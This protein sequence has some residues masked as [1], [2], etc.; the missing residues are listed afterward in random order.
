M[1]GRQQIASLPTAISEL[2]KNAHDA[3]ARQVVVDFYRHDHLFVLRDD[4][5]GMTPEEFLDRWLTLGTESKLVENNAVVPPPVDPDQKP[6]PVL[7]EK[8][9]GRL[10]VAMLG[11]HL[12]VL[13]RAKSVSGKNRSRKLSAAF[14]NWDV[15]QL[16][17]VDLD[18]I[19]IPMLE[20]DRGRLPT[21]E[22][23]RGLV[24]KSTDNLRQIGKKVP[25]DELERL[26]ASLKQFDLDPQEVAGFLPDGPRLD[27]PEGYGTHFIIRPVD[28][29]LNADLRS[30]DDDTASPLQKFLI[31]FSDTMSSSYTAPIRAEFREHSA[32]GVVDEKIG[33]SEFFTPSDF[34]RADH[35]FTGRFDEHGQF[36][37]KVRIYDEKPSRYVA[38]WPPGATRETRCGPFEIDFAYMQ[39]A[40]S[41]SR[42]DP[43]QYAELSRKLNLAGGLY[44]YRDGIRVLPYGTPEFDFLEIEYRRSKGAGYYYFSHR[45]MFGAIRVTRS[46]NSAL[47]EKAGREGFRQNGAYRDFKDV[48]E[49]FLVQ[50]A[51]DFF[52]PGGTSS[53]PFVKEK[54]ELSRKEKL[55]RKREKESK[56]IRGKLAAKIS[57]FLTDLKAGRPSEDAERIRSEFLQSLETAT[58]SREVSREDA[59]KL[60]SSAVRR[61]NDLRSM[62][63]ISRPRGV[64][65][66]RELE[67]GLAACD[68]EYECL[69]QSLFG[70]LQRDM[71]TAATA[72]LRISPTSD[73]AHEVLRLTYEAESHVVKTQIDDAAAELREEAACLAQRVETQV[74]SMLAEV[75]RLLANF[76]VGLDEIPSDDGSHASGLHH[77]WESLV[78]AEIR[79]RIAQLESLGAEIRSAALTGVPTAAEVNEAIEGELVEL[80]ESQVAQFELLQLGLAIGIIQHEFRGCVKGLRASLSKLKR[81]ADTNPQL[82]TLYGDIRTNFDH[83]DGYLGLFT[84]LTRRLYRSKVDISG[85][86]IANFVI[87][88]FSERLKRHDINLHVTDE[89]KAVRMREYPSSVYPCF[90]NLV[91]NSIYWL[92]SRSKKREIR[93]DVADGDLLVSD[94]GPGVKL[95]DADR[96]FELGFT[97]KPG[98]RGMGLYISREILKKIG[99]ELSVAPPMRGEGAQFRIRKLADSE[100][101]QQKT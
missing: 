50:L 88:L 9:I 26:I 20:T 94:S 33:P 52:R 8:G 64:G 44:I 11:P 78:V 65:L 24:Q 12:L 101:E 35:R 79:P 53:E 22:D 97:R 68:H 3:Y 30:R 42:L 49:N 18:Q 55:R 2:F 70:P 34:E 29:I 67:D 66:P 28:E 73:R 13:T 99:Y 37:G 23:V 92:S 6:R 69:E 80:R 61:V 21:A 98:G 25:K 41:E 17:A 89:F 36:V 1:L 4:G 39:G 14:I 46:H 16:P 57:E 71:E 63:Q 54:A 100:Q 7:G 51:A 48:L 40:Q 58:K 72:F 77:T 76:V 86:E 5:L 85:G 60:V 47:Q 31:G 95:S 27:G 81:W 59:A 32:E 62:Y 75:E 83:L 19:D 91:D 93:L 45:R 74:S 56:A 38:A 90:V 82:G 10:A 15:F 87:E 43:L 96:I 84:P